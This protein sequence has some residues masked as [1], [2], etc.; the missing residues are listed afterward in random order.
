MDRLRSNPSRV[1]LRA[2]DDAR[3]EDIADH[4]QVG[5]SLAIG[6]T[7]HQMSQEESEER[8]LRHKVQTNQWSCPAGKGADHDNYKKAIKHSPGLFPGCM[9]PRNCCP[10]LPPKAIGP[11]LGLPIRDGGPLL[12]PYGGNGPFGP[13][14]GMSPGLTAL[15]S[16]GK[17]PGLGDRGPP[18]LWWD[19]ALLMP[20]R[21]TIRAAC[22]TAANPR[23]PTPAMPASPPTCV[24][25]MGMPYVDKT[26]AAS[27]PGSG[28]IT[29]ICASSFTS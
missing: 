5:G 20:V 13:N 2:T 24:S 10:G 11:R 8:D 21:C 16:T 18:K 27:R 4:F 6:A 9:G 7:I 3:P 1:I 12:G 17:T 14:P 25:G 26:C 23:L 22:A 19:I 29:L 28:A 15:G